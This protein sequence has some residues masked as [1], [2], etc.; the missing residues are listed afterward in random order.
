[1][2]SDS[3]LKMASIGDPAVSSQA[4][5]DSRGCAVPVQ[6]WPP[7]APRLWNMSH[8]LPEDWSI[9][10]QMTLQLSILLQTGR[11]GA[12]DAEAGFSLPQVLCW[13]PL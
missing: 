2:S 6:L 7:R 10:R 1:M 5:G 12:L 8:W 13:F 9:S 3:R 4:L 11:A